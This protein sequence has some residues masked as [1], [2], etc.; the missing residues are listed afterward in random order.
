MG[1]RLLAL[2]CIWENR[3]LK[4]TFEILKIKKIPTSKNYY[5]LKAKCELNTKIYYKKCNFFAFPSCIPK[6][7]IQQA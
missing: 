5:F 1:V 2:D 4:I 7:K 3:R 6:R